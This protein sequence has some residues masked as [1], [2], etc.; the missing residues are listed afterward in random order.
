V[1]GGELTS[2]RL[3]A[4]EEK[5]PSTRTERVYSRAG[6]KGEWLR[7]GKKEG[8]MA[9]M[10]RSSPVQNT[11]DRGAKLRLGGSLRGTPHRATKGGK[12]VSKIAS[13][14]TWAAKGREE[15]P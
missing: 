3:S 11:D 4:K 1:P 9:I 8:V 12:T 14:P 6:L 15:N 7:R 5:L 13:L 2:V 10:Q